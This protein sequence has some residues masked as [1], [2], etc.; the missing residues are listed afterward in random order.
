MNTNYKQLNNSTTFFLFFLS[1]HCVHFPPAVCPNGVLTPSLR[2]GTNSRR[3]II[4]VPAALLR[5]TA[6]FII[7]QHLKINDDDD[8]GDD[9]TYTHT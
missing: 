7:I 2:F 5:S 3:V 6:T 8:D 4:T 9:V 1:I